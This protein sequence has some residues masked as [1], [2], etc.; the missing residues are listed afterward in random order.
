M[1]IEKEAEPAACFLSLSQKLSGIF[2]LTS[3]RLNQI[4][5]SLSSIID[6]QP[7]LL[8]QLNPVEFPNQSPP[9]AAIRTGS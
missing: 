4:S 5:D 8:L 2:K 6:S 1:S 3:D 7:S 9:L